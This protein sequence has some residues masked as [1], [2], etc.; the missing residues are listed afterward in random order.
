MAD[1]MN[2]AADAGA[3]TDAAQ[4]DGT[5]R[6]RGAGE[7]DRRRSRALARSR[8]D[9]DRDGASP[10]PTRRRR[11][12]LWARLGA[13]RP[14]S[15]GSR[16]RASSSRALRRA[17]KAPTPSTYAEKRWNDRT[18]EVALALKAAVAAG[19]TTDA[20]WAK[21]LINPAITSDFLPLLRRGDDHR[22]DRRACAKCPFNVNVPAQTGGG[23]V[24][25]VGRAE[26]EAR[27]GDGLRDGEPRRST[28]SRRSSCSRRNSCGSAIRRPRRS[29]AIR[30]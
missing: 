27:H 19:T 14:S 16:W 23:T 10:V 8:K 13:S 7:I 4:A 17:T 20:T 11:Q 25:W 30:W 29:S 24:A 3:T 2:T 15:P 1:I 5:R 21:P 28:K 18:P 6:P 26:A 12:P 9:A 22:E